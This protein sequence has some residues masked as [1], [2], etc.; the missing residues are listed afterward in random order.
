MA[1]FEF[2]PVS[3]ANEDGLLALG[4]DL[5]LNS[6]LLAYSQGIFPW[7]ISKEYP[8]A[9]FSPDPRGILFHKDLRPPQKFK[10]FLNKGLFKITYNQNFEQ[11]IRECAQL[12]NRKD[13]EETWISEEI[14]KSYIDF[15]KSGFAYSVEAWSQNGKLVGGLYGVSIGSFVSGE[16]MFYRESNASKVALYSLME[17]LFEKNIHWLDTQ[18][19]TSVVESFGGKEVSRVEY[20]DILK[21]TLIQE[22]PTQLFL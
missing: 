22:R 21:R 1:I 5:T 12:K 7:P 13:L 4:G 17:H 2:P 10:K 9:W 6:L 8:L 16:S 11:V 15:H 14:I 3:T 20:L 18:M 19:V